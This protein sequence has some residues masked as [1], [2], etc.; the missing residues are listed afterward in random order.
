MPEY[1]VITQT[2]RMTRI[3]V[4]HEV[5]M[6]IWWENKRYVRWALGYLKLDCYWYRLRNINLNRWGG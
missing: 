6:D 2:K 1:P 5:M 4:T 3:R